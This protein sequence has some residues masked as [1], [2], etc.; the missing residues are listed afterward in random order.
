MLNMLEIDTEL[1]ETSYNVTY[2]SIHSKKPLYIS[3]KRR[4][5]ISTYVETSVDAAVPI[6]TTGKPTL[7][8]DGF[9]MCP[10]SAAIYLPG[11]SST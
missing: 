11:S 6:S 1:S 7:G 4:H 3:H 8:P 2:Q 10:Y 5:H 9:F